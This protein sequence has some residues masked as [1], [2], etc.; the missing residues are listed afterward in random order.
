MKSYT[1]SI[2][3]DVHNIQQCLCQ[4]SSTSAGILSPMIRNI[5]SSPLIPHV[6]NGS[7]FSHPQPAN[8]NTSPRYGEEAND[9][10]EHNYC[11]MVLY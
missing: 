8:Q 2:K 6:Q 5:T 9:N 10:G 3:N 4:S 1:E 11:I 7:Q